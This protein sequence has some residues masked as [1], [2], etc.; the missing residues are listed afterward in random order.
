MLN[1][2]GML[3]FRKSFLVFTNNYILSTLFPIFNY[4]GN[5]ESNILVFLPFLAQIAQ[6]FDNRNQV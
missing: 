5:C 4:I 3:D 6:I 1:E 2:T